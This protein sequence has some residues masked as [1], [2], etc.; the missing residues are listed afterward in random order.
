MCSQEYGENEKIDQLVK[1]FSWNKWI[2]PWFQ[3]F[4]FKKLV[5]KCT[6]ACYKDRASDPQGFLANQPK[7]FGYCQ[8][9]ERACLNKM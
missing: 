5:M 4:I 3:E 8:A 6:L 1:W 9:S 2:W 7:L